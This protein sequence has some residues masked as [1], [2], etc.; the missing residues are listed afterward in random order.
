MS[1]ELEEI[2]GK[3]KAEVKAEKKYGKKKKTGT[4]K[5]VKK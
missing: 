4:K 1:L 5:K 3:T 2:Q